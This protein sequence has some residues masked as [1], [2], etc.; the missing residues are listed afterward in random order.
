MPPKPKFDNYQLKTLFKDLESVDTPFHERSFKTIAESNHSFYGEPTSEKRKKFSK[1]VHYLKRRGIVEYVTKLRSLQVQPSGRTLA[2]LQATE[3][4]ATESTE[5]KATK[6]VTASAVVDLS[7]AFKDLKMKDSPSSSS[8][9]SNGSAVMKLPATTAGSRAGR[10][11]P[12]AVARVTAVPAPRTPR[13][14]R[15]SAHGTPQKI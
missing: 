1:F 13:T 7:K 8:S 10:D 2:E 14:P 12:L 5:A 6:Q 15:G 9:S 3:A 11:P 4:K